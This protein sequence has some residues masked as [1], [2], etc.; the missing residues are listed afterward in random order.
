MKTCAAKVS[1]F[2]TK[3]SNYTCRE[4]SV[5]VYANVGQLVRHRNERIK[6]LPAVLLK[7][8]YEAWRSVK[9]W[10]ISDVSKGHCIFN[11]KVKQTARSW[12]WRWRHCDPS[13]RREP[14]NLWRSV[15]FH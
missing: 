8:L 15:I 5:L 3:E 2:I 13:K 11:F 12:R 4:L 9:V 14:H 10:V 7:L 6:V 1:V